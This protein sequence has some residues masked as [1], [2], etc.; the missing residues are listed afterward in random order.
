MQRTW[1]TEK[2]SNLR[3]YAWKVIDRDRPSLTRQLKLTHESVTS[4]ILIGGRIGQSTYY[5]QDIV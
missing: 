4:E 3:L 1:G 5:V 2:L